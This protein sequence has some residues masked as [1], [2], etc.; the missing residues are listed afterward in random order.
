MAMQISGG[1]TLN[2]GVV[3]LQVREAG[4]IIMPWQFM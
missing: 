4:I 1:V 3:I 2:A